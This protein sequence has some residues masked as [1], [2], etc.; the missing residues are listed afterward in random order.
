MRFRST[1]VLALVFAAL[2]AYLYLVEFERAAHEAD[3]KTLLSFET[4]DVKS[5]TL[6]YPD[7]KITV[8]RAADD[9]KITAPIEAKADKVTVDN[10]VRAIADCEVKKTLDDVGD[11]VA[12]YGLDKPKV[13]VHVALDKGEV[14]AIRVGKTSPVG[15]STY[16]QRSDEKK[17]Y[18]TNSAFQS[19]ME[20][21][22]KDLRDKKIVT[23][24]TGAVSRIT[25]DR[26]ADSTV[27]T[28]TDDTWK[29][30]KPAEYAAD[31]T[32]VGA[33]ISSLESLRA[34]DFPSEASDDLKP[35]G[36]D[37]PRLAVSLTAG[38]DGP[39][40]R[41]LFGKDAEDKSV[42]VKVGDRPT[43]FTV[44]DWSYRDSDKKTGDLRDKTIVA[45]VARDDVQE[46]RI[47]HAGFDTARLLRGDGGA[48]K[49][50]EGDGT[51]VSAMVDQFL[52]DLLSLK[53][54]EIVTD[55][56]EDLV[57]YGLA[58]ANLT[59]TLIGKEE[60]PLATARFGSHQPKPPATEYTAMR[61]GSPTVFH[62]RDYQFSR[63]AKDRK[64]F[65]PQ[66]TPAPGSEAAEGAEGMVEDQLPVMGGEVSGDQ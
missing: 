54:Y 58:P 17:V 66:P 2:G 29:I 28:K 31:A 35:F 6:E 25:L 46:I 64:D 62:V 32:A 14:P 12:A 26:G 59:I 34:K 5:V 21:Q 24:D 4:S 40:T 55:E 52:S 37:E 3:K 33:L 8:E 15:F 39:V 60:K 11:D 7:R 18:L 57:P 53:G 9:W 50:G 19:G 65:L 16:L 56:A 61:A 47:D 38:A 1:L 13:T 49:F 23:F 48:W 63:I 41:I 10:L 20:K 43:I 22:V 36:L 27:L 51:P 30:E 45:A 44:G 42:Y